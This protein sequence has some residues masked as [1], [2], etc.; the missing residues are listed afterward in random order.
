MLT[1]NY[2]EQI[3]LNS[4]QSLPRTP[5]IARD[6]NYQPKCKGGLGI[7][8][9]TNINPTIFKLGWTILTDHNNI[10]VQVV[11]TKYLN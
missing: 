3:N 5:L 11:S 6:K 8:K 10:W 7:G 4:D 2:F 1:G 9:I